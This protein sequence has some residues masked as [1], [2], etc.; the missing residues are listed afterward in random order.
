MLYR[1]S[2]YV[3]F[4]RWITMKFEQRIEDIIFHNFHEEAKMWK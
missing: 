3:N 4:T 2:D 1:H